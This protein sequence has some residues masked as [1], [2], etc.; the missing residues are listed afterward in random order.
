M[1]EVFNDR[2]GEFFDENPLRA[3]GDKPGRVSR[4]SIFCDVQPYKTGT[5]DKMNKTEYGLSPFA[6]KKLF[7]PDNDL[8]KGGALAQI[9]GK[10]YRI[11]YIEKR[12]MGMMAIAEEVF[13]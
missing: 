13:E 2:L 6:T 9:D 3:Y 5:T 7:C 12:N 10:M 11:I 4:G 8:I 1:F